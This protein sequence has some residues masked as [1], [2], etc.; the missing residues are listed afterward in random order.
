MR[1][2]AFLGV[3]ALVLVGSC[4]DDGPTDVPNPLPVTVSGTIQNVNGTTIPSNARAIVVWNVTSGADY[5][6][7][8]GIGTVNAQA[9]TFSITFAANP[10][11]EA[12]NAGRLGVGLIIL[13]TDASL[14]QGRLPD[15]ATLTGVLG[16]TEDHS[17]IFQKGDG[18]NSP[19]DWPNRFTQGYSV[20]EVERSQTTF[21]SFKRVALN[22]LRL[23]V[24]D[25]ANLHPPN[26][27]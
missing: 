7:V 27:T 12:L 22:A 4:G 23:V 18:S 16:L 9:G 26:W 13:T 20:G 5:S 25:L 24:D 10:P 3:F 15:N 2:S 17:V 21:D 1:S 8:F 6:Y 19:T 14:V 11:D